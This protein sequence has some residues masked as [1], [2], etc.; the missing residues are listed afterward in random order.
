MRVG[1]C[2]CSSSAP[3]GPSAFSTPR[4]REARFRS[5]LAACTSTHSPT[6]LAVAGGSAASSATAMSR[7]VAKRSR[8]CRAR[9]RITTSSIAGERSGTTEL[10]GGMGDDRT[11]F[12]SAPGVSPLNRR[13][14]VSASHRTTAAA[15]RSARRSASSPVSCSGAMYA[16]FPFSCPCAVECSR[17]AAF[18]M[19]KSRS[20]A[21][22]STPTT[23]FC[24]LTS[25]CTICRGAPSSLR[26]SC[27]A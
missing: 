25:R 10:G 1:T 26:A 18:A 19:P 8:F 2:A 15:K 23:M 3:G 21:V 5:E 24:G 11:A 9:P 7:A 12:T 4:T 16:N 20:R 13:V 17:P 14:P 27:A 22:P 6:A